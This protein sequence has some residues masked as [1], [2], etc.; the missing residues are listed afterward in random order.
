MFSLVSFV[1]VIEIAV[2]IAIAFATLRLLLQL[3]RRYGATSS[4]SSQNPAAPQVV[5]TAATATIEE[6]RNAF[7]LAERSC[8]GISEHFIQLIFT[9][10]QPT[11]SDER[12]RASVDRL[13]R[14]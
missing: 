14:R 4:S 13:K 10:L 7:D 9:R 12:I 11:V 8:P 6:L 5:G 3:Q 1:F 2:I